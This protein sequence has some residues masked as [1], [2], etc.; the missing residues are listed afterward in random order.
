MCGLTVVLSYSRILLLAARIYAMVPLISGDFAI[1][2]P[3]SRPIRHGLAPYFKGR[4]MSAK[5]GGLRMMDGPMVQ[6][7]GLVVD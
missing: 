7:G 6:P 1:A 3:N 4:P 2:Q 5:L